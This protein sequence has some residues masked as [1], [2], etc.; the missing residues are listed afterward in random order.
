MIRG[1]GSGTFGGKRHAHRSI[2]VVRPLESVCPYTRAQPRPHTHK[3]VNF[4][5]FAKVSA[6]IDESRLSARD[7]RRQPQGGG[8]V[9]LAAHRPLHAHKNT[10][11]DA[12]NIQ[13]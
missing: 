9:M 1:C 13:L 6:S 10:A 8:G 2:A 7:L 3:V 5:L 4:V 11:H 12:Q